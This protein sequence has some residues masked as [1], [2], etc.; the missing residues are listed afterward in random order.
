MPNDEPSSVPTKECLGDREKKRVKF[1]QLS[2]FDINKTMPR[3]GLNASTTTP[4]R[5]ND[6]GQDDSRHRASSDSTPKTTTAPLGYDT[7]TAGRR[8]PKA[9]FPGSSSAAFVNEQGYIDGVNPAAYLSVRSGSIAESLY[10]GRESATS[11]AP[12]TGAFGLA[13]RDDL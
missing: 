2:V 1:S 6:D 9:S 10:P 7:S 12:S 4:R 3:P 11:P 5:S 13:A 8:L